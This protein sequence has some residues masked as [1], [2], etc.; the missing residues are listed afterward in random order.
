MAEIHV[1]PG[2]RK[3][4]DDSSAEPAVIAMLEQLLLDAKSGNLQAIAFAGVREGGRS[5]QGW[6]IGEGPNA[7]RLMGA[8]SYLHSRYAWHQVEHNSDEAYVDP[9]NPA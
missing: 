8:I 4:P 7:V 6:E 2:S 1:L 9:D 3:A 5:S